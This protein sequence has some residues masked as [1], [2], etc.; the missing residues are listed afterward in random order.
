MT[1]IVD[2]LRL[3][4]LLDGSLSGLPL[5]DDRLALAGLGVEVRACLFELRQ[6]VIVLPLRLLQSGLVFLLLLADLLQLLPGLALG[7]S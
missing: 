7:L 5:L 1:H 3:L 6:L 4:L 2:G